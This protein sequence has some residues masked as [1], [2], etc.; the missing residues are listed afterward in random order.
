MQ[1]AY[2]DRFTGR[3]APAFVQ[4]SDAAGTEFRQDAADHL[5]GRRAGDAVETAR[6]P[7]D[8]PETVGASGGM[9]E[10]VDHAHGSAEKAWC[11]ARDL[12]EGGVA[13]GDLAGHAPGAEAPESGLR[14]GVGVVAQTVAAPEDLAEE[15]RMRA[16][17]V[18]AHEERGLRPGGVEEI[19]QTG[20]VVRIGAVVDCEPDRVVLRRG[21]G[22]ADRAKDLVVRA[23][24]RVEQG[25]VGEE[26]RRED[27]EAERG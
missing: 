23:E 4:E 25:G 17:V 11:L 9:H 6:G 22:R 1:G 7:T 12:A 18:A 2:V 26:R 5:G 16:G 19:E 13:P 14:M 24:R 8:Q 3:L 15:F 20:S 21:K 10:W 27:P